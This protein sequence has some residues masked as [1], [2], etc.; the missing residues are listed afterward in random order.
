VLELELIR[1]SLTEGIN[2]FSNKRADGSVGVAS[3]NSYEQPASSAV[4]T[5][6]SYDKS[7]SSNH[8]IV[9][10]CLTMKGDLESEGDI[11]VKGKVLGNIKCK[12]L[13]VDADALVEGGVEAEEVIIRGNSKGTIRANRV[14]LEKTAT[15]DSD[16]CHQTFAAEEG[17]R[18][19]GALRFKDDPF[20]AESEEPKI[21][22]QTRTAKPA[23]GASVTVIQQP[24]S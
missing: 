3:E 21:K 15:V 7:R 5:S 12:M 9:D 1:D 14:R 8:S 11:L 19:K 22:A 6:F 4:R 23:S 13:I 24:S 10:E 20:N 17:A 2:M 16:I 18:I